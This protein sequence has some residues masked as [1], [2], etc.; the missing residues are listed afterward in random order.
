MTR[1]LLWPGGAGG[2]RTGHKPASAGKMIGLGSNRFHRRTRAVV[3]ALCGG[4][5]LFALTAPT[6]WAQTAEVRALNERLQR[7]ERDVLAVCL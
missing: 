7:L 3:R 2:D 1:M 6:V 5:L 4:L